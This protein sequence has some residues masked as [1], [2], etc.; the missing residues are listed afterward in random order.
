[1]QKK[2]NWK[3][4]A[5]IIG[6]VIA[7]IVLCVF[8]IQGAQNK[9][10]TYE[11]KVNTAD[12]N[13]KVQEKRRVDIVYNLADCVKHYDKH[14][15]D[16]LSENGATSCP[17]P[18]VETMNEIIYNN[19]FCFENTLEKIFIFLLTSFSLLVCTSFCKF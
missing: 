7:V 3:L 17:I 14:E 8:M 12:S 6:S 1:M 19:M 13:I 16:M 15:A 11:E 4:P 10:Y 18:I 9:A 2:S 5:I